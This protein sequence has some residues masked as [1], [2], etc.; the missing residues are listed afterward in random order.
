MPRPPTTLCPKRHFP[1]RHQLLY[2]RRAGSSSP[3]FSQINVK[4]TVAGTWKIRTTRVESTGR[5]VRFFDPHAE[6]SLIVQHPPLPFDP[7]PQNSD[8]VDS[9]RLQLHSP[10]GHPF[11]LFGGESLT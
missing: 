3:G 8:G 5:L 4:L 9:I 2:R 6:S 7:Q 10:P 11:G 1:V